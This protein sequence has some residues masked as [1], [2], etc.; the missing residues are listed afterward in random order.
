MVVSI[1][2]TQKGSL[3]VE[4]PYHPSLVQSVREVPVRVWDASLKIRIIPN[5]QHHVDQLLQSLHNSGLFTA[6]ENEVPER[7]SDGNCR[8]QC[9]DALNAR[10]Y[11]PRTIKVYKSWMDRVLTFHGNLA[12]DEWA[13]K[14]INDFLTHLAVKENV[15]PSTQNQALSAFL[16][17]Y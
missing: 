10:H 15:S 17:F 7:L 4:I 1:I 12:A 16:F 8:E 13:D 3:S 2:G 11:S 14:H 9:K 6:S 5:L